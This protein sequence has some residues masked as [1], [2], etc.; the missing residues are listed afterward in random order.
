MKTELSLKLAHV[1]TLQDAW[2]YATLIL[3]RDQSGFDGDRN[4]TEGILG[5]IRAYEQL[6]HKLDEMS[7]P[8]TD[9]E[10]VEC[11][12][13]YPKTTDE[14]WENA[15]HGLASI[16]SAAFRLGIEARTG[17]KLPPTV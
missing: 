14:I 4:Y 7:G 11:Q 15:R 13:R 6:V 17:E 2:H 10:M 16:N 5:Q 3:E 9:W 1:G 12:F 8:E